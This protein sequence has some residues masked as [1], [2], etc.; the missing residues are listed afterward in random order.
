VIV[1]TKPPPATPVVASDAPQCNPSLSNASRHTLLSNLDL[2]NAENAPL[3]AAAAELALG[4][5]DEGCEHLTAIGGEEAA[6]WQRQWCGARASLPA[7]ARCFGGDIEQ[8]K[9]AAIPH[10]YELLASRKAVAEGDRTAQTSMD[11]H[12]A[13]WVEL[14]DVACELGDRESCDVLARRRE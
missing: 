7:R 5:W 14:M 9:K 6:C 10:Q 11:L 1:G 2:A 8:C 4:R 12:R 13:Q 3:R